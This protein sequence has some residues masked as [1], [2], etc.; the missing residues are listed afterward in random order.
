MKRREKENNIPLKNAV[1]RKSNSYNRQQMKSEIK[2]KNKKTNMQCT[3]KHGN[4]RN[5]NQFDTAKMKL[6]K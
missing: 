5:K 2:I 1:K 3:R 4:Q 6:K